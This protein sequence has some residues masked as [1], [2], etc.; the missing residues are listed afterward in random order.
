VLPPDTLVHARYR[1]VRQLGQ[2][3]MGV[4]YEAVDERLGHLVALKQMLTRDADLDRAFVRE[5]R[6]LAS[7]RHPALPAVTD[8]FAD[9]AGQFLVMQYIPGE[10]LG[11]LLL[12]RAEPFPVEEVL[13]WADRL[14]E[15]LIYLHSQQPPII[16]RDIKPRNLKQTVTGDIILLDFGLARV[17]AEAQDRQ[18]S[19]IPPTTP[20]I[21]AFTPQYAPLEQIEGTGIGPR[22]DLYALAATLYHLVTATQPAPAL[23]RVRAL[24]ARRRDP[25]RPAHDLNPQVPIAFSTLLSQALS[26][27]AEDRPSGAVEMRRKLKDARVS[28]SGATEKHRQP[29]RRASLRWRRASVLV[30]GLLAILLLFGVPFAY[31]RI[32]DPPGSAAMPSSTA[33]A[34]TPEMEAT[35][36]VADIPITSSPTEA[37]T[38]IPTPESTAPPPLEATPDPVDPTLPASTP[39]Q[40]PRET[41]PIDEPAVVFQPVPLAD[42]ANAGLD[43]ESPPTGDVVLEG[44]PFRLSERVFKS[45]SSFSPHDVA[46]TAI[47]LPVDV[48]QAYRLHLLLN[49]GNGFTLFASS[50]VGEIWAICDTARFQIAPLRLGEEI[51]EWHVAPKVVGRA[52]RT[53]E[54]WS[55]ARTDAPGHT[56]HIDLLS[57]DLPP[58]CR[59]GTL[60][61]IEIIDLS[62]ETVRSLDPAL[63]LVGVTVEHYRQG[64]RRSGHTY[65]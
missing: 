28:A 22:S 51:R 18:S 64:A 7:L 48:P 52:S 41:P 46:P 55:G 5:A 2:G 56:G 4:I 35:A 57:L 21:H 20:S 49:T 44:V 23:V 19:T 42:T 9:L 13:E 36:L 40:A 58:T 59:E 12:Q 34:A 24:V 6:L 11:M 62:A 1:V 29:P 50:V 26:L 54:V 63:N 27:H 39:E 47:E 53:R 32:A 30:A 60:E 16:H 45:Q 3:G 65:P 10:D 37:A 17:T 25:L 14:L 8:F 38:N 15:V 61:T 33:P 43:F 31:Q